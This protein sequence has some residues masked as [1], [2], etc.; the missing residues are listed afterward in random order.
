MKE[1]NV[2]LLLLFTYNLGYSQPIS[3]IKNW[4]MKVENPHFKS[5]LKWE[6]KG[7][8]VIARMS[9]K[10]AQP[11]QLPAVRIA[12]ETPSVDVYSVFNDSPFSGGSNY[13]ITQY[14][15]FGSTLPL[16]SMLSKSQKNRL[17]YMLSEQLETSVIKVKLDEEGAVFKHQLNINTD[18]PPVQQVKQYEFSIYF[19]AADIRYEKS[20]TKVL[21]VAKVEGNTPSAHI[22][23]GAWAPLYSTWY[24]YHHFLEEKELLTECKKARKMGMRTII[25][26][27]GWMTM[28]DSLN[29][30]GIGDYQPLR[31][32]KMK[33]LVKSI[34]QLDMK[35]M[36][37]MSTSMLGQD[38]EAAKKFQGKYIRFKKGSNTF[39]IDPRYPEVRQY[40]ITTA[41]R[42]MKDYGLDGLKLDFLAQMYPD[43]D[44]PMT[45]ADGR[46][47][48]SI[49]E[50]TEAMIADIYSKLHAINPEVLI[51][52]R[53]PY[54][55]VLTQQ[56]ANMF[57]AIDNANMEVANRAY[58][59]KIKLLAPKLPVHADMMLWHHDDTAES[60]ALQ[61]INTI[62]AVPQV[63]VK[64]KDMN[65]V[66]KETVDFW[67]NFYTQ[68][69][70]VLMRGDFF[71]D[72]PGE[73]FTQL[74]A[75][76]NG[77]QI[78][79]VYTNNLVK[80][81]NNDVKKLTIIDGS[82][83]GNVVVKLNH[84][85]TINYKV[86]DCKGKLVEQKQQ[87]AVNDFHGFKIPTSGVI[88]INI[89]QGI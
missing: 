79:A 35:V 51:E 44:T 89:Q 39:I 31:L 18:K 34:Q 15:R 8:L 60:L 48:A 4:S 83:Q 1:L 42:L 65:K 82:H 38:S 66:Q 17:T 68:H 27:D 32:P 10:S 87:V 56:Y 25:I 23:E 16:I 80:L 37:W 13:H 9:L 78:S 85:S 88:E 61:F 77:Q 64:V 59:A 69:E 76:K 40:I 22:P 6:Q 43:A 28:N 70:D 24:S 29:F 86:F 52:F 36:L 73:H 58:T 21:D 30:S 54:I 84:P 53:Q 55:N 46:D 49:N 26:D 2:L 20:I 5:T 41:T 63:S 45:K 67:L 62:F 71:A 14:N 7:D 3:L 33:H 57:R 47:Y 74:S 12:F 72:D 19:N 81:K 75:V 50:A 11:E